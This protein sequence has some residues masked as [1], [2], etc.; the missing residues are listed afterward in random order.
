[1]TTRLWVLLI[2]ATLLMPDSAGAS[3]ELSRRTLRQLN[4]GAEEGN[5]IN[6]ALVR[7]LDYPVRA[8]T[9]ELL[10]E[11]LLQKLGVPMRKSKTVLETVTQALRRIGGKSETIRWED[12][13]YHREKTAWRWKGDQV[14]LREGLIKLGGRQ[15]F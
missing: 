2:S 1:V 14:S 13:L 9:E 15:P 12:V 4:A 8:G 7:D 11:A 10:D 6:N 3:P 5:P